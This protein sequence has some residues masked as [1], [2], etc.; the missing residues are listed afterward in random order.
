MQYIKGSYGTFT[1]KF[2]SKNYNCLFKCEFLILT[3]YQKHGFKLIERIGDYTLLQKLLIPTSYFKLIDLKINCHF[4]VTINIYI[5]L[6][7][8][9]IFA[10]SKMK[11][12][13]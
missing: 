13:E 5:S 12:S 7:M 8:N 9:L 2:L 4:R 1:S 6:M 3:Q 10:A 11:M